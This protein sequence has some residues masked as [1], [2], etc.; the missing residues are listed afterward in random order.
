MKKAV[1]FGAIALIAAVNMAPVQAGAA[2]VCTSSKTVC[3]QSIS[4]SDLQKCITT[5]LQQGTNCNLKVQVIQGCNTNLSGVNAKNCVVKACPTSGNA[6]GTTTSNTNTKTNTSTKTSTNTAGTG[7]T[8]TTD[9][10]TSSYAKQV[11]NL[12][13]K[14]R[15]K[16]GL[17]ALTIDSKVEKA[18]LVRAK[19]IQSSFSHTRPN[20]SMFA[21]ALKEAGVSYNGAGE[22]IA[23]GQKTPE[24]VVTAWMNSPGHR[25]NILN[26]NFKYIGVG[27]LQNSS[28]AQYW[29]QLFTY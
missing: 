10:S 20:G 9:K 6:T 21:S 3:T 24:E 23:W 25:A 5:S 14:E 13:N 29:V 11:V 27:N 8:A 22:N 7:S 15:A 1:A 2:T 19:E 16:A 28:G 18:A 12:V 26:K 17:S 4:P